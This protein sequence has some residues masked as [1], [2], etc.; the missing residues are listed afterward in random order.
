MDDE[1]LMGVLDGRA[2]LA[3][4]HEPRLESERALVAVGVEGNAEDALHHD[5]GQALLGR[6]AVEQPR[7]VGMIE[8][9][10]DAPLLEE[11]LQ[12]RGRRGSGARTIL[13]ATCFSKAASAR[14]ARYTTPIPPCPSSRMI[15]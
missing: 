9:R 15:R 7:D 13:I 11:S 12:Q 2:H 5:V 10:Q 6:P 14:S 4:E 3:E 1:V 8:C